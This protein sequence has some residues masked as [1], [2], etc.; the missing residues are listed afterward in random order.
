MT[1]P[2]ASLRDVRY[3]ERNGIPQRLDVYPGSAARADE[4]DGTVFVYLHGGGWRAGDKKHLGVA[5][6]LPGFGVTTISANYTLTPESPYPRNLLDVF[7]LLAFVRDRAD[8]LGISARHVFLG[9]AS[10]GGHLA[11]LAT[12][13][14]LAEGVINEPV[15]GVV[16]WYA[17]LSPSSRYLTHRY[18]PEQY[19]GGFWDRGR[20][21][22]V[23]G[24]DPYR[25]F[26]GTDDFTTIT[27]ADALDAD[28]RFHLDRLDA[29][30]LPPFLLLSGARD[31][32]EIRSS[33]RSLFDALVWAG[34]DT[35]LLTVAH[36]DHEDARF[37][38]AAASGA[39]LGFLREHSL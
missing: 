24:D 32:E 7:D 30:A 17:P 15:A 39:V 21:P 20:I 38:S 12:T 4:H 27:L 16:S 28:P 2:T 9:G 11:A 8:A 6:P 5:A 36:A 14:G 10:A 22:G 33:Q 23:L 3:T 29:D 13:K 35:E 19:P 34:V 37:R 26:A 18:S 25:A 31:S 1:Q